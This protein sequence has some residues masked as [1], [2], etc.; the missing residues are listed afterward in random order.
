MGDKKPKPKHL[1]VHSIHRDMSKLVK[2]LAKFSHQT[3]WNDFDR[4]RDLLEEVMQSV[5]RQA[6][7]LKGESNEP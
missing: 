7:I 5:E 3:N 1:A 2:T 6:E 4:C